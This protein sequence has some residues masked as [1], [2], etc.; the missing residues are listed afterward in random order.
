MTASRFIGATVVAAI[1]GLVAITVYLSVERALVEHLHVLFCLQ[2]LLQWDAA[3]IYGMRAF[4]G[5]WAM[6][7]QGLWMDFVV[8]LV[9]AVIFTTLYGTLPLVRRYPVLIGLG[10]GVAVMIVMIF[11]VVP[12]GHAP[13]LAFSA[14][15][16][17]NVLVAHTVF[18]GMPLA[19]AVDNSLTG[20]HF[21]R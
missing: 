13:R 5:G 14:P 4:T 16:L 19:I 15:H 17:I 8:S 18:Y 9:W 10:Y 6:A 3:N 20:A 7:W 1:A 11:V 12:L 2:Q 21:H